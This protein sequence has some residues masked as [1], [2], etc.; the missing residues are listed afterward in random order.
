MKSRLEHETKVD[1]F[2]ETEK[3]IEHIGLFVRLMYEKR[4]SI[5][6]IGNTE[7]VLD[8]L[9]FGLFAEIEGAPEDIEK[10]ERLLNLGSDE[11]EPSVPIR[12]LSPRL[13]IMLME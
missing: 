10:V 1:S 7:V 5:W 8:E 9:P 6:T 13:A 2:K 3:I 12:R 11:E 4:R